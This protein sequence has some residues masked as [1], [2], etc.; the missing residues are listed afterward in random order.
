MDMEFHMGHACCFQW[1]DD[2][3]IH[4]QR[5]SNSGSCLSISTGAA[6][7]AAHD[8][9]GETLLTV[10]KY[11]KGWA[12]FCPE[13]I[14]DYLS[15]WVNGPEKTKLFRIYE[16]LKEIAGIKNRFDIRGQPTLERVQCELDGKYIYFVINHGRETVTA[17]IHCLSKLKKVQNLVP[18]TNCFATPGSISFTVEISASH[19]AVLLIETEEESF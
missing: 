13:P 4:L 14:E 15:E 19:A 16:M 5:S 1:K 9:H 18:E 3:V 7:I 8:G 17:E 10:N 11:G 6:Q 2:E 12:V